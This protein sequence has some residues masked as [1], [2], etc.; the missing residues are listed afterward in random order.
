M[1]EKIFHIVN[2]NMYV[3]IHIPEWI[4]HVM[5]F[6]ITLARGVKEFFH[7]VKI[8]LFG[9]GCKIKLRRGSK[10]ECAAAFDF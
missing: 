1:N 5:S 4:H 10:I 7:L 2:Q 3:V 9:V 8:R 6:H